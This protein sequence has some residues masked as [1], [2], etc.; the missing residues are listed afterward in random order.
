LQI[1]R[2]GMRGGR[3]A[4]VQHWPRQRDEGV[5]H[6][7]LNLK[8]PRRPFSEAPDELAEHVLPVFNV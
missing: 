7:A 8:P 2:A 6:V 5:N 1:V 4:L 3:K